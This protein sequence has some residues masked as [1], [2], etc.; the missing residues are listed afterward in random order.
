LY[1]ISETWMHDS[2]SIAS[3]GNGPAKACL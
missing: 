1:W 3:I 2:I